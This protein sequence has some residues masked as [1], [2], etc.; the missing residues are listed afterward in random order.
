MIYLMIPP[1][2]S[3]NKKIWNPL[4]RM[5]RVQSQAETVLIRLVIFLSIDSILI[6]RIMVEHFH[7]SFFLL[8]LP[9]RILLFLVD[10]VRKS[11]RP[12]HSIRNA[13][14]T[15]ANWNAIFKF[16]LPSK[17]YKIFDSLSRITRF[18]IIISHTYVRRSSLHAHIS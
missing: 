9:G 6:T 16:A 2:V 18:S 17:S 15:P 12:V 11:K 10:L 14:L 3:K 8:N 4:N 13:L 5:P 1:R 7:V